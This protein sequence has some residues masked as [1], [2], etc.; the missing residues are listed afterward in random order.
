MRFIH[1]LRWVIWFGTFL[2]GASSK[3]IG[4]IIDAE[5]E[6]DVELDICDL[7]V[8]WNLGHC[9]DLRC[10]HVKSCQFDQLFTQDQMKEIILLISW[11][12]LTDEQSHIY[13]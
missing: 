6:G 8:L 4:D 5:D 7:R 10:L 2:N 9:I 1:I 3:W 12:I 11:Y 13:V